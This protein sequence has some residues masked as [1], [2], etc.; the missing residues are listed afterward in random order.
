MWVKIS[1][2]DGPARI[3]F[4]TKDGQTAELV[5]SR[6]DMVK[7]Q[8]ALNGACAWSTRVKGETT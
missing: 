5:L 4:K 7:L 3:E 1:A 8:D 2:D 6:E